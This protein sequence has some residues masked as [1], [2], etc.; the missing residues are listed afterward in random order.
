VTQPNEQLIDT[1]A[2][3]LSIVECIDSSKTKFTNNELIALDQFSTNH[4]TWLRTLLEENKC[5]NNGLEIGKEAISAIAEDSRNEKKKSDEAIEMLTAE[6]RRYLSEL[7]QT[8]EELEQVRDELN[9]KERDLD[10]L[11]EESNDLHARLMSE[12]D[13]NGNL[14]GDLKQVK[15]EMDKLVGEVEFQVKRNDRQREAYFKLE[16][17]LSQYKGEPNET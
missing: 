14:R 8:R 3:S 4:R 15:A 5:L 9:E 1:I 12:E 11:R 7:Q 10:E 6:A 13:V 2:T 16:S 17:E